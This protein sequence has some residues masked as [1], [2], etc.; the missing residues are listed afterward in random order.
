MNEATILEKILVS[1]LKFY[2]GKDIF[3]QVVEAKIYYKRV[4]I[5]EY[6]RNFK[7]SNA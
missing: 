4:Y 5:F 7:I 3:K 2:N 1:I 6:V